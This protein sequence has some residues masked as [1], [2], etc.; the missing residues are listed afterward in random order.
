LAGGADGQRA[1]RLYTFD[2]VVNMLKA[3]WP[4]DWKS[5]LRLRLDHTADRVPLEGLERAGWKLG[6]ATKR[7]AMDLAALDPE[8]PT[9]NLNA[10]LGLGL[11]KDGKLT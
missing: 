2:D 11:A 7:S 5:F 6:D 4:F 9:L 10:S 3:V 8:K 1:P